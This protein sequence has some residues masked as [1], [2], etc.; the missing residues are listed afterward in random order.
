MLNYFK[1]LG[2]HR[3]S[4]ETEIK[5]KYLEYAKLHHPDNGGDASAF[6]DGVA[7]CRTL[8]APRALQDYIKALKKHYHTCDTCDGQGFTTKQIGFKDSVYIGCRTCGGSGFIIF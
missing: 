3:G 6:A 2:V 4:S 1:I 5:R 7:A 8:V